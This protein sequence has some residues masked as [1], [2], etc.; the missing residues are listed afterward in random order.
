MEFG[1][2]QSE[3]GKK[4]GTGPEKKHGFS[5]T[6]LGQQFSTLRN[7]KDQ[8]N[9]GPSAGATKLGG[10]WGG[11]RTGMGGK[12]RGLGK[13]GNPKQISPTG[14]ARARRVDLLSLISCLDRTA[15]GGRAEGCAAP[16]AGRR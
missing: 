13:K 10:G 12:S 3:I 16:G 15:A 14:A 6:R 9:T 8:K 7:D 1:G 2:F 5:Y 4:L 11:G